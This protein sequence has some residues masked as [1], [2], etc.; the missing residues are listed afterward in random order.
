MQ[1]GKSLP[2]STHL[3]IRRHEY[4]VSA[5]RSDAGPAQ[6]LPKCPVYTVTHVLGKDTG[7]SAALVVPVFAW[8]YQQYYPTKK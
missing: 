5:M 2:A 7:A 6:K 3:G 8:F 4:C 1:L